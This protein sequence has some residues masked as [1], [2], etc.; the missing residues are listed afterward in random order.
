MKLSDL[1]P[2]Y[3]T[4]QTRDGDLLLVTLNKHKELCFSGIGSWLKGN[5]QEDFKSKGIDNTFDIVA[6]YIP[7]MYDMFNSADYRLTTQYLK[8]VYKVEEEKELTVDEV[9]QLLGYKVKII[10]DKQ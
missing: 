6:V 8:L 3:H 1:I 9:S 5:H 10:G 4:V 7:K 2:G